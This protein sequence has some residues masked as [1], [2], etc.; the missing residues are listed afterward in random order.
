MNKYKRGLIIGRF[1]P[2]HL[3]H[4]ELLSLRNMHSDAFR[5]VAPA[6]AGAAE[7][8]II[9]TCHRR[10]IA[11]HRTSSFGGRSGEYRSGKALGADRA[12]QSW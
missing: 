4:Y 11:R 10:A 7:A 3:A 9:E 1:Q 6:S 12:L 2:F 5:I 8:G